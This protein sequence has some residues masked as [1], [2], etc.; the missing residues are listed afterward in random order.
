VLEVTTTPDNTPIP[1]A[2]SQGGGAQIAFASARSGGVPQIYI[3]NLDLTGL[4]PLTN[5]VDG[6]CQPSW[7][8][9]GLQIVFISPCLTRGDVSEIAYKDSSLYVMNADGSGQKPLTTVPGSDFDP[10]W[11]PDGKR[12]AFTSLRDGKKDIYTLTIESGAITRLTTVS[13][14][15]Q[16]NSQPSWSPFGNQIVY[17]A[18]R[19]N[20]FQIW[21]MNDTGQ[22]NTQIAH[23]GQQFLDFLPIWTQDGSTILFSQRQTSPS[24]AWLMSIRFEDRDSKEPTRLDLPRPIEDVEFSPDGLWMAFESM[25]NDGNRDVYFMT[26]SGGSRT[27]LTNDPA[28]DFD[29]AWRPTTP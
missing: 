24:R 23:S 2:T 28:V 7:S 11:S 9:D 18:K 19:V 1:V 14:D 21:A 22:G 8:P 10:D 25:D 6:A 15:V 17:T 16:E 5:I 4:T 20:A 26:T 29:P 27:R 13:G 3:V 12:I